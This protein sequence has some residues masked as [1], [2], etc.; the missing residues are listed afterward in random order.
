MPAAPPTPDEPERLAA[1]RGSG[2]LD[3]PPDPRFDAFA[4]LAARVF[5][6]PIAL[7]SLVDEKR[8]WAKS[9]IG[10]DRGDLPREH[11]FCAHAILWPD[12]VTV[13]EDAA[14]DP[15]FARNPLVTGEP[16]I[17]FYVGAPIVDAAGHALGTLCVADLRPR[18][19]SPAELEAL[20][21][22]ARGAAALIDLHRTAA[23]TG[24]GPDTARQD[25]SVAAA[26]GIA[27]EEPVGG[28]PTSL[29][30]RLRRRL[31]GL[32]ARILA[33]TVLA[34]APLVGV[35]TWHFQDE[36]RESI[37]AAEADAVEQARIGAREIEATIGQTLTL[38]A[39]LARVPEL[40]AAAADDDAIAAERCAALLRE[41]GAKAPWQHSLAV[42][43][44]DGRVACGTQEGAAGLDLS[45][46]P[47]IQDALR[48][49]A[50][51]VSDFLPSE[52]EEERPT[53]YVAEPSLGA[54][55]Q[56][57]AIMLASL[58]PAALVDRLAQDIRP[59]RRITLV[60]RSGVLGCR[61]PPA[62]DALGRSIRHLPPVGTALGAE[63]TG[64]TRGAGL[65]DIPTVFG[66]AP[67][68]ATGARVLVSVD[69]AT[70]LAPIRERLR[71]SHLLL[72]LAG[73]LVILAALVL[74]ELLV[75][76]PIR[77]L[78]RTV[79]RLAH[80]DLWARA[81][82]GWSTP[83]LEALAGRVNGM[84]SRL[85][86]QAREL[87]LARDA[88]RAASEAKSR[89]LASASH[90]LRT[91]LNGVLGWAQL[92]RRDLRLPAELR[93]Q[94]DTIV[95]AGS[96]LTTL[97]GHLI[98]VSRIEAGQ[99]TE[100]PA[101]PTEVRRLAEDCAAL[102]RPAAEEKGLGLS[103]R[104]APDVP[105]A[106]LMADG[107][108]RQV[109]LNFLGNAVKFTER[110]GVALR[111]LRP[112]AG[113]L[114]FE[115]VDTGPGIPLEDRPRLFRD[116]VRL[117]DARRREVP[118]SGLGLSVSARIAAQLGGR[119]GCAEG[120]GGRGTLF[121]LELPAPDCAEAEPPAAAERGGGVE[122]SADGGAATSAPPRPLRI[123]V[124]DDVAA[125][126]T[127]A[128]A[129]LEASAHRV[130]FAADGAEAVAAVMRGGFDAVL[131]DVS[132]PGMDGL[133][134]TRRIR[135]AERDQRALGQDGRGGAAGGAAPR[136][137]PIL[138]LTAGVL[139]EQLR[140]CRD[141][142]M[143][144]HLEKPIRI[145]ALQAALARIAPSISAADGALPVGQ[146]AKAE[147]A[148]G[149]AAVEKAATK[150][151]ATEAT[152]TEAAT[153]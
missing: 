56:V 54:G 153:A 25:G 128:R 90:E 7:L 138:A 73:L 110:G 11:S 15:R 111:V 148:S 105:A 33:F 92:L 88:A 72:A 113:T 41:F 98:D 95:E 52:E 134:A 1:L 38:L 12:R 39:A 51:V 137:V 42:V 45:D 116:F 141:A 18:R 76:R 27:E 75:L 13:V 131:M 16:G 127:L 63:G 152:T 149:A 84:A 58:A 26:G 36:A 46:R 147:A 3:T 70:L 151:V 29:A 104:I 5:G 69:E 83:E 21:D 32:R 112:A 120:D 44:P 100:A 136:G 35:A 2:I 143:D 34:M 87:T 145:E 64:S 96:H 124:V 24:A 117:D 77:A 31:G 55:D 102:L 97:V 146:P 150:A 37:L 4:R 107:L 78:G 68:G 20:A 50:S 6:A 79:D 23:A 8:Q 93:P 94:V 85:A 144:G 30:E 103:V 59:G 60:D 133:E 43:R 122:A 74:G 125:N 101:N 86:A 48:T 49:R 67:V 80:G 40:L 22:L 108:V 61:Y 123:L 135:A 71:T 17:R 9:A 47:Y 65:D 81:H 139:P 142:G 106:S 82:L 28:V 62:P 119:V 109:L 89:F 53:L 10:L 130:E 140:V 19:P 66:F 91:P 14:Q 126:R 121:W 115:V 129:L 57:N 99:A 118:G 114:R 132:M